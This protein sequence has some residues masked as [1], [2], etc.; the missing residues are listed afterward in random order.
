MKTKIRIDGIKVIRERDVRDD[1]EGEFIGVYAEAQ[2]SYPIGR[3]NRRIEWLK[4]G[5]V[6]GVD[7][8]VDE[9]GE[10]YV[11]EIENDALKDLEGHLKIFGVDVS[12]FWEI[13]RT[14]AK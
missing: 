13:A 7:S 2:V 1:E 11:Q 12:N 10:K 3:G 5:G 9:G 4:S 8:P 14:E 6:W